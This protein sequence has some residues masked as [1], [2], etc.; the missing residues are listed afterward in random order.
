MCE[1]RIFLEKAINAAKVTGFSIEAKS[2]KSALKTQ[3][4]M[5]Y[6]E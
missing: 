5:G 3:L 2:G 6:L 4:L 1:Q